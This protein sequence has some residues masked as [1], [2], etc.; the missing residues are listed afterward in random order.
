MV[1]GGNI[2]FT[3]DPGY[4]GEATF[5]YSITDPEGLVDGALVTLNF[6]G[7]SEVPPEAVSDQILIPEDIPTVIVIDTLLGNDTDADMDV[8]EFIGWRPLNGLGDVFTFGGAAAGPLNGTLEFDADGN[9]LFTPF[10]DAT[11]SSGFVYGISDFSEGTSE[12]FVDIVIIPSNDDP[13]VVDDPGFVT[14]FDVPLV[15]R[16]DDLIFNDYDI[17]QADTDGDGTIDVDLDDPNR[18]RPTFVGVDRILDPLELAQGNRVDVGTFEILTFRGEDFL[19]A[20]FDPGFTGEVTIQ[21]RIADEEGLEDVGFAYANVADF[22]GQELTGT[23]FVDY[24][25]GNA[26]SETI[27]GYR[28]DDHIVAL[29]GN[30]TILTDSGADLIYAG[31]GNDWIDAGD[32]GDEIF[33]GEGFDTVVFTGSN[34]GLRADLATLI[35][36]GG[37]AQGDLYID[38]EA[39]VGTSFC[40]ILGGDANANFLDGVAGDDELEGREGN[41]TLE[42]GTGNDTLDG[43]LDADILYGGDGDDTATYFFSTEAVQVSLAD[44]S[45]TGGWAEGDQLFSVENL[46]GSEFADD[47]EGDDQSNFLGGDRGNDTITANAGNDTLSGGEGGIRTLFADSCTTSRKIMILIKKFDIRGLSI[48]QEIACCRIKSH[49]LWWDERGNDLSGIR[50]CRKRF[51]TH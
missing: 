12:G 1:D 51:T 26:L 21:Y 20:R 5:G 24:I 22:Y 4:F 38:V 49:H 15:I 28:R 3:P 31:A 34:V 46:L 32:D 13:T 8:I 44:D 6:S 25:E 39:L 23:P 29:D 47:L 50:T 48:S 9:L 2:I 35:G 40:D 37:F 33:G 43:G 36:Q 7:T 18:E 30:D 19:V 17:E 27:F 11:F 45:A 10:I 41:D 42:G 14:P 16:A